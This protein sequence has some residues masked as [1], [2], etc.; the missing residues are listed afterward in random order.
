MHKLGTE[1]EEGNEFMPLI[2]PAHTKHMAA[3]GIEGP[4]IRLG[5]EGLFS[6]ADVF[7][8][9]Q[10]LK[11]LALAGRGAVPPDPTEICPG[12]YSGCHPTFRGPHGRCNR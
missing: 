6:G 10:T 11:L 1:V 9:A 4:D 5:I 8:P 7:Q 12:G 2:P 3:A